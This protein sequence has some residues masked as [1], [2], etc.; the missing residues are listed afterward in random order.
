MLNPVEEKYINEIKFENSKLI[1]T[2]NNYYIFVLSEP[3]NLINN[4]NIEI[5]DLK[6]S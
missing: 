4:G 5:S 1:I 2:G 6:F 3:N